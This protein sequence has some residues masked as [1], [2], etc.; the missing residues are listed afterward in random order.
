MKLALVLK[1][2]SEENLAVASQMG[3]TDIVTTLPRE[4]YQG[5]VWPFEAIVRHKQRIADAGLTWSVVESV[6]ISDNVKL[7]KEGRDAEIDDFARLSSTSA[8]Q[9]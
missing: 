6:R 7:G 9:A 8:P 3:V 2:F 5:R 4:L 1:P